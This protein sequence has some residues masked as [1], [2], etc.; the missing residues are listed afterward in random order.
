MCDLTN[1]GG[2]FVNSRSQCVIPKTGVL[3]PGEG[4]RVQHKRRGTPEVRECRS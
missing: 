2:V 3:Q 4:S 1:I